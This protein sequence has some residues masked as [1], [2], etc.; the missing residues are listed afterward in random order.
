M[1]RSAGVL[2]SGLVAG[3]LLVGCSPSVTGGDTA[4][5][6][7]VG[8]DEKTQNEA[9]AKMLKDEKGQE[10]ATLET[11]GTRISVVAFC[12]TAGK[13]DSK[14]KEAPHL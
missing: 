9:V 11:T 6:D 3:V 8:A 2:F 1:K 4:C 10:P 12:Q 14:I 13:Q 7:F 5:K